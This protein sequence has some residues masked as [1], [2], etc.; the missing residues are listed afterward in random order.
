MADFLREAGPVALP[1]LLLGTTALVAALI[2]VAAPSLRLRALAIGSTVTALLMG[3]FGTVT[4]FQ[5][6]LRLLPELAPDRRWIVQVGLR[7]ALNGLV[8]SL[9]FALVVTLLLTVA[10]LRSHNALRASD[11]SGLA[12]GRT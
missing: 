12:T 9:A 8:L 6:A 4:G 10:A 5:K 7:E 1:I 2:H 3:V 11:A